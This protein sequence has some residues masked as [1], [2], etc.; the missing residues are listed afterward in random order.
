MLDKHCLRA[1]SLEAAAAGSPQCI[2]GL[3]LDL[4]LALQ[5]GDPQQLPATVISRQAKQMG[6]GRSL[7]A[8]LVALGR[9]PL[10]LDTQY[11]MH[12][13]ISTWPNNTFY[14]GRV[15]RCTCMHAC[16]WH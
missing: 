6:Y 10:L 4:L 7:F 3:H 13:H 11:R 2:T 8:R 16:V 15:R 1:C 9:Q 14:A 5:V 12:P